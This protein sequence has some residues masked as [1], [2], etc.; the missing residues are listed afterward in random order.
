MNTAPNFPQRS[1]GDNVNKPKLLRLEDFIDSIRTAGPD[2]RDKIISN[3]YDSGPVKPSII[4]CNDLEAPGWIEPCVIKKTNQI[5]F[6]EGGLLLI[7]RYYDN[8]EFSEKGFHDVYNLERL[9]Q[10]IKLREYLSQTK[11]DA[12]AVLIGNAQKQI[13]IFGDSALGYPVISNF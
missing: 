12:T 1:N 10:L 6:T 7:E 5:N 11:L 2:E 4:I 13:V 8:P 9:T 3:F